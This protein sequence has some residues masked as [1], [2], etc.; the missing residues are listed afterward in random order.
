[1]ISTLEL[2]RQ[3][4]AACGEAELF[5]HCVDDLLVGLVIAVE[6][7]GAE[8][9]IQAM[10]T[11]RRRR[12]LQEI[13]VA[14]RVREIVHFQRE[15]PVRR[16]TERGAEDI[17]MADE[18]VL[19]DQAAHAGAHQVGVVAAGVRAVG[20]VD[21]GLE[22]LDEDFV[23]HEELPQEV[24]QGRGAPKAYTTMFKAG[25]PDFSATVVEMPFFDPPRKRQ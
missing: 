20:G 10:R 6:L 21:E 5:H 19:R 16:E 13:D 8:V 3:P 18:S 17:R 2:L 22:F 11:G 7:L 25:F 15:R 12:R 1:M 24:P 14:L 23:E 9:E 4:V